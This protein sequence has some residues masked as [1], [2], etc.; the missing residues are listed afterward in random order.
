MYAVSCSVN[1]KP[2]IDGRNKNDTA[3]H[4]VKS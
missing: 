3:I 2:E 4:I 1:K